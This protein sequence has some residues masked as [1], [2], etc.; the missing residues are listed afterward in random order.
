ME[1]DEQKAIE[2]IRS[3]ADGHANYDDD[4]ILNVIDMIFDYYDENGMLDIDVDANGVSK[5]DDDNEE[6][7]LIAYVSKMLSKDKGADI[8]PEDVPFIV[9]GEL[10]YEEYLDQHLL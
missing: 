10:G 1:Y 6:A 5:D 7:S 8:C 4:Q 2:Y 3:H 9:R